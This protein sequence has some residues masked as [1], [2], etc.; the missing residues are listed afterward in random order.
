MTQRPISVGFGPH[1]EVRLIATGF[2]VYRGLSLV[3]AAIALDPG[4][5]YGRGLSSV[6]AHLFASSQVARFQ[7]QAEEE[8]RP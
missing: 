8:A 4:T 7:K 3:Q 5:C 2:I 6:E 1:T